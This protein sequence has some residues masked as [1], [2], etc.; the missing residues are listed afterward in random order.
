[1][2]HWS[3]TQ[4]TPSE[5]GLLCYDISKHFRGRFCAYFDNPWKI[6]MNMHISVCVYIHVS[7]STKIWYMC[8]FHRRGA[9]RPCLIQSSKIALIFPP[10]YGTS[11]NS[12][13]G[14]CCSWRNCL[15]RIRLACI[16]CLTCRTDRLPRERFGHTLHWRLGRQQ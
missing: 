2:A 9:S 15:T 10:D 12:C 16:W 7:T 8:A 3:S 6:A 4:P 11:T 1:M 13:W 5:H 14:Q